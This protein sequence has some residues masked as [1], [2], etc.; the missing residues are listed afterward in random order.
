MPRPIPGRCPDAE[1]EE[2]VVV[3]YVPPGAEPAMGGT[4]QWGSSHIDH[5]AE[6]EGRNNL[7]F[8]AMTFEKL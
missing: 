6:V 7:A 2:I 3:P 8:E 5:E 4:S 1:V